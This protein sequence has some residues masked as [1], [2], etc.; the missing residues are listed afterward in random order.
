MI[1]VI[2][3]VNFEQKF[4]NIPGQ[5]TQTLDFVRKVNAKETIQNIQNIKIHQKNIKRKYNATP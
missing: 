3:M 5:L 1:D 4:N 2:N